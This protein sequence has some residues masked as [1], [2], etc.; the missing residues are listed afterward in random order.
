MQ[1]SEDVIAETTESHVDHQMNIIS[2]GKGAAS[3]ILRRRT[4]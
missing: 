3:G 2:Y 1:D 4:I